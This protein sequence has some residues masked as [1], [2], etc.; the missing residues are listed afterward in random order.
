MSSK[1]PGKAPG[2][3]YR[4]GISVI[5][6]SEM[7]STEELAQKWFEHWLW[8]DKRCCMRCG[9]LN[10]YCCKHHSMPYR[11][12][13]CKRYFS[14]KTGTAMERSKISLRKW[15]WAI[16]LEMT[17]LKGVSSMKLHRDLG[18]TQTTAWF[19]L[20]RIRE[21]FKS[22]GPQVMLGPVEVDEAF[23]GGRD[24][25]RH[26]KKKFG[27]RWRE[28]VT[29]VVA[30]KDRDSNRVVAKVVDDVNR[31]VLNEFV[32]QHVAKGAMVYTDGASA[33][34]GRENHE[35]VNH[36]EGEFVRGVIHT[37]SVEA[38]WSMLKRAH[39]GVY[40]KLSAKHLQR[41]ISIAQYIDGRFSFNDLY[42]H[43]LPSDVA[44]VILDY[45]L[46][47]YVCTGT[48][49]EKLEWFKTINIAG[50]ELSNQELRNA[51]YAGPWVTDAKRYFSRSG[52]PA[53]TVGRDHLSGK[54][55]RQKYLETAIRW[56]CDDETIEKY[57]AHHQYHASAKP[58]WDHFRQ[59]IDWVESCFETR[60]K[61][62]R[63][64][65]WGTL[66]RDHHDQTID[67]VSVE[68]ETLRLIDDEDVQRHRG[69][70]AYILT[71]D[72]RHLN[73]R[74]FTETMKRRAYERQKGMCPL[75]DESFDLDAMDADH[76]DPWSKG[77]K[78]T[79]KNCQMLCS[80]CNRRK[81]Q[82]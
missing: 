45:E 44:K 32:D 35:S 28:G 47:V 22:T 3:S 25:N 19:M 77:G 81:G 33:Y 82:T 18:V 56:K 63:G 76:I 57:M 55:I 38:F 31:T 67:R 46:M 43:N 17:S 66:Y 34:R 40:H 80:P 42:F 8:G 74:A 13:D 7:F 73:I 49:S 1:T 75:C 41:Y 24:R 53:Y 23:V 5:E 68:D 60:P 50:Q 6:M 52:A 62:M 26:D 16:Y 11:C 12:R 48:D 61:L 51:V 15:G 65:D 54:A 4:K 29:P 71:R 64:I 9:S 58:L 30:A 79:E 10:T 27:R 70:Y 39:K 36:S 72:E 69:I 21:A 2:K 20:H 37:N 78:T 14:V 59:V